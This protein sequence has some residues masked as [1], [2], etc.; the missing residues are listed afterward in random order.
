MEKTIYGIWLIALLFTGSGCRQS[1]A[2][3][4]R[5]STA[6]Q[7]MPPPP[8]IPTMEL[9]SPA[10]EPISTYFEVSAQ[11]EVPP[12]NQAFVHSP[13]PGFIQS[14]DHI[15]GDYVK[16]GAYLTTVKHQDL[17][18]LQREFLETKAAWSA[19]QKQYERLAKLAQTDAASLRALES[20]QAEYE[21][22]QATH[23]G[24]LE[25]LELIGMPLDEIQAGNIQTQLH[26]Y[27]PISGYL[28][29]I[30]ARPGMLA[31]PDMALY[32]IVH[33]G[34]PHLELQVFQAD[35]GRI[36]EGQSV[37]AWIP[38][39]RDTLLAQVYRNGRQL[40]PERRTISVHAHFEDKAF[41]S[42]RLRLGGHLQAR[43]FDLPDSVWTVPASALERREGETLVFRKKG[44]TFEGIPVQV[45]RT[46]N[47][48]VEIPNPGLDSSM[49]LV[50]KGAYY[51]Q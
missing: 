41:A 46:A 4:D 15:P 13:V 22:L 2:K 10:F 44:E 33:L 9:G 49:Q 48:R 36:V 20:A 27:A 16:K 28:T 24:I 25:E 7:P 19:A 43:I 3:E 23:D 5:T 34:H 40:D 38:G 42:K 51:V 47:G 14:V 32:Q 37:M 50:V 1:P 11:V 35:I 18:R 39:T 29:S 45:G 17:V 6:S 31:T 26:L 30:H 8:E 12:K 21:L